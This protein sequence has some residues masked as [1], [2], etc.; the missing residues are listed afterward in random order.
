MSKSSQVS[1]AKKQ[2]AVI[3]AY[4]NVFGTSDGELVLKDLMQRCGVL[5]N[6]FDGDVNSMLVRE[7]KRQV[8]LDII[9][10]LK[11][12]VSQ[13]KERIDRYANEEI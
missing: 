2:A 8:V 12:D 9:E 3:G 10:K 5:G 6:L 11:W 4:Q 1:L 7:G 13:L